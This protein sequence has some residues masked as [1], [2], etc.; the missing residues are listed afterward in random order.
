MGG[1]FETPYLINQEA[2]F[3]RRHLYEQVGGVDPSYWGAMDY[4]LWLRT[5]REGRAVYL[6]EVLGAHRFLP[7][8]KSSS[9]ERYVGEMKRARE[10]FA[11]LYSL[12]VPPWPFTEKGWDRVKEKW[13]REWAPIL[14][15]IH[16]GCKE[17]EWKDAVLERWRCYAQGGILAVREQRL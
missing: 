7:E 1:P 17:T 5:F 16:G 15:W 2:A 4:D 8:Q 10:K 11:R 13:E 3:V 9:S 6:P 12:P 14:E